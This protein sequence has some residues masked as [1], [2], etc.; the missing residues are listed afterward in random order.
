[1]KTRIAP[2]G[3]PNKRTPDFAE[4]ALLLV[5]DS[6]GI[7]QVKVPWDDNAIVTAGSGCN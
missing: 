1:M 6:V 7:E 2:H 3:D 5:I 4:A